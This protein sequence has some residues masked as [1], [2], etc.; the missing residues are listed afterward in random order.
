MMSAK[1]ATRA[2]G[3]EMPRFSKDNEE[4]Y[5]NLSLYFPTT[6]KTT[7]AQRK[8]DI[9][10]TSS[11]DMDV[12]ESACHDIDDSWPRLLYHLAPQ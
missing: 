4:D 12:A 9:T 2:T 11:E 7:K 8:S 1:I 6:G 3:I 5:D 10:L